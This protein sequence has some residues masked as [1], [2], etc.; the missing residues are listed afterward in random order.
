MMKVAK[1]SWTLFVGNVPGDATEQDLKDHLNAE[2]RAAELH[3]APGNP[4]DSCTFHE[5]KGWFSNNNLKIA[6][7]KFRSVE[8]AENG[9][10]LNGLEFQ[11]STLKIKPKN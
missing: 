8:E 1:N 11:N 6:F 4:V 3:M 5:A 2:M 9:L 10:K 7:A